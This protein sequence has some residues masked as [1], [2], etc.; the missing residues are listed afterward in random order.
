MIRTSSENQS[1][2]TAKIWVFIVLLMAPL[3]IG[4]WGTMYGD[5]FFPSQPWNIL[6]SRI[7]AFYMIPLCLISY[8]VTIAKLIKNETNKTVWAITQKIIK[9]FFVWLI[10]IF[11]FSGIFYDGLK[12]GL[13]KSVTL[14][15]GSPCYVEEILQKHHPIGRSACVRTL[16]PQDRNKRTTRWCISKTEYNTLPESFMARI[17]G[18]KSS[19]GFTIDGYEMFSHKPREGIFSC[20]APLSSTTTW[21]Y[22]VKNLFRE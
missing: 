12:S 13:G 17:Y 2:M 15:Q 20:D 3:V 8:G 14:K 22:Q 9:F 1:P 11:S 5:L 18:Q 10:I 19:F 16:K 7:A 6:S 4:L 21:A